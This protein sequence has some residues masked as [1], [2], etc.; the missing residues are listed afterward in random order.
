MRNRAGVSC[1]ESGRVSR[2]IRPDCHL[3]GSLP[4]AI[5]N[6]DKL[7]ALQVSAVRVTP[8]SLA[9]FLCFVS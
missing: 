6:L 3:R 8:I 2:I 9:E 4:G 1:D 7:Q 5:R